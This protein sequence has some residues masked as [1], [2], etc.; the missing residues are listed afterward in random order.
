MNKILKNLNFISSCE[1]FFCMSLKIRL[2]RCG[3]TH[4]PH[5]TIVVIESTKSR[6]GMAVEKIGHYHPLIQDK[7]KRFVLDT[8]K[9]NYWLSKGAR[10]SDTVSRLAKSII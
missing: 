9:F 1:F 10:A 7:S 3:S 4:N 2:S 8:K 6:D 5:Y